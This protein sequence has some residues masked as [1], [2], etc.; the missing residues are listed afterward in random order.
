MKLT[1]AQSKLRSL[2]YAAVSAKDLPSVQSLLKDGA[3]PTSDMLTTAIWNNS[4]DILHA[5]A[6]SGIDLETR[7]PRYGTPLDCAISQKNITAIHILLKAGASPNG[8]SIYGKLL[9][10]AVVMQ[11]PEAIKA[12]I[13]AGADLEAP[14]DR[15]GQSPLILA[16]LFDYA[17]M[18][19]LLLNAGANPNATD[20]AGNTVRAVAQKQKSTAVLKLLPPPP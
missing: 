7:S 13:A 14:K 4:H 1:R 17:D 16:A 19:Q 3:S 8:E 10:A 6:P 20:T 5:L 11:F 12:L 9:H 18:A 15:F 2:L